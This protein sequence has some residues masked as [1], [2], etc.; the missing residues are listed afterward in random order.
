MKPIEKITM[1]S[2]LIIILV[3]ISLGFPGMGG[4]SSNNTSNPGSRPQIDLNNTT[5]SDQ[6]IVMIQHLIEVD[7]VGKKSMNVLDIRET[8][9]FSNTG[10]KDFYGNLSTWMEDG[11][12][13]IRVSRSEMMATGVTTSLNFT[14]TGNVIS[15]KDYLALNSPLILYVVEYEL[16][17]SGTNT[18]KFVKEFKF[19]PFINYRYME[20]PGLPSVIAKIT[21]PEGSTVAFSDENGNKLIAG[22]IDEQN[23]I[24]KFSSPQFRELN[25]E[26]LPGSQGGAQ[27]YALY[28]ILGILILIALS[29]PVLKSKMKAGSNESREK[30]EKTGKEEPKKLS[31][32][33]EGAGKLESREDKDLTEQKK[34]IQAKIKN[35]EEEYKS[36]NLL[37]EEYEET[38][39]SYQKS[40]DEIEKRSMK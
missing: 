1:A 3:N 23:G 31:K 11:S 36:G 34:Q 14:K 29:Y 6:N 4:N 19:P 20:K 28:I 33:N 32:A 16:P 22:E 25:I 9:I 40:L 27:N 15:W 10:E 37:D 38:L 30:P 12:E 18:E 13:N 24:Y 39:K 5:S 35:L 2:F 8:L 7:A 26:I 17:Q 21:K